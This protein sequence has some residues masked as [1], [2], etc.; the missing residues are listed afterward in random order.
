M[1][2]K[3]LTIGFLNYWWYNPFDIGIS[4]AAIEYDA[5]LIIYSGSLANGLSQTD[6]LFPPIHALANKNVLD[7]VILCYS[8]LGRQQLDDFKQRIAQKYRMIPAINIGSGVPNLPNV[9]VD[10]YT[11]AYEIIKHL[12]TVHNYRKIAYLRGPCG[13]S[14]AD[15]RF[16]A[17]C[18]ALRDYRIPI[19]N[20]H[21]M[22]TIFTSNS[23]KEAIIR[24]IQ[25]QGLSFEAIACCSDAVAYG[26]INALKELG[27]TVPGDVAVTGFDGLNLNKYYHPHLTSVRQPF[28]EI[29]KK[30]FELLFRLIVKKEEPVSVVLP[31]K[32]IVRTSCGCHQQPVISKK[33]YNSIAALSSPGEEKEPSTKELL[34]VE[35][36]L[37]GLSGTFDMSA[38]EKKPFILWLSGFL[39]I[40]NEYLADTISLDQ[41]LTLFM[42]TFY[43]K[44]LRLFTE[45]SW[46]YSLSETEK[47]IYAYVTGRYRRIK[48]ELLF[49]EL[50][51]LVK[52]YFMETDI[53][54]FPLSLWSNTT[55]TFISHS[56][57]TITNLSELKK[58]L[59]GQLRVLNMK[60]CFIAEF[61]GKV[62]LADRMTYV[63]PRAARGILGVYN[64]REIEFRDNEEHI[65][66]GYILPARFFPRGRFI[67]FVM[68]LDID[69]D[70][71]GYIVFGADTVLS[72]D[73]GI[74]RSAISKALNHIYKL[75]ELERTKTLA[76]AANK[77]KSDFLATMSHE[78]R[79]P[80]NS[81]LGFADLLLEEEESPERKE[82]LS[83]INQ[84]GKNLL[85]IINDILDFSKI[86]AEQMDFTL[87]KISLPGLFSHFHSLFSVRTK[88]KNL[89]FSLEIDASVP[90][91]VKGD[92]QRISQVIINLLS[93]ACKFTDKGSIG[94][95]AV[96]EDNILILEVSDTG[97]GIPTEMLNTIFRPFKQ[98]DSSLTRRYEGTGLG[99]AISRRL[100]TAMNGDIVV[101][102]QIGK[103]STFIVRLPLEQCTELP[104]E[105][106][107]GAYNKS[108]GELGA[109]IRKMI[110]PPDHSFKILVAEDDE[111]NRKL[112][113][114]ILEKLNIEYQFAANGKNA[115]EYI[116]KNNYDLIFL[117]IHMPLLDGMQT[118]HIIRNSDEL[119]HLY[120]IAVTAYALKEDSQKYIEAGC[121]DYL[122][123]PI[124]R[125][126][127]LG[128]IVERI[129]EKYQHIDIT[130]DV[131]PVINEEQQNAG[132]KIIFPGLDRSAQKL[133]LEIIMQL[134]NCQRI[135]SD[136]AIKI[137][138][139]KLVKISDKEPFATIRQELYLAA[140][141][142]NIELLAE[143]IIDLEKIAAEDI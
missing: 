30:A 61:T 35:R 2:D 114:N 53:Y 74:L 139:D 49:R 13:N 111:M 68:Y 31:A 95:R 142:Y 103:G 1:N 118:I 84:A 138:A 12:I 116:M 22:E 141:N 34:P 73:F 129:K 140:E 128:K 67:L 57:M 51:V 21:I 45:E 47:E 108:A 107:P 130:P 90:T 113:I 19:N 132:A 37:D 125:G 135:F 127:L 10:N 58:F 14:D 20:K 104:P 91:Y 18:D 81:I 82:K 4:N 86:E 41:V 110:A 66:P 134:K 15:I 126:V 99:L 102:S 43:T 137:L 60:Y 133:L 8:S 97:I 52:E 131:K 123:K 105:D 23:G 92:K 121:D 88:K 115:L 36:I 24:L 109:F 100:I 87:E 122:S 78:I 25:E 59:I 17:Y 62:K 71:S 54:E 63:I 136:K 33:I 70:R 119:R 48:I 80:L 55:L 7:G 38:G 75:E 44:R 79:T 29:G 85:D 56:L 64:Y 83:T 143:I 3:R 16:R 11:G 124:D 112:Y 77:A 96:Y 93:N 89:T 32:V 76:E 28:H 26:A 106:E 9:S 5:N 6:D 65:E 50:Y 39:D 120:V 27:Y 98:I 42:E 94:L 69:E 40:I 101:T 46:Q 117:D 72:I